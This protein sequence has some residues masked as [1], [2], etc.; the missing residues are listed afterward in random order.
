M[1][2]VAAGPEQVGELVRLINAAYA[3]G[4]AGLWVDGTP[5]TDEEEIGPAVQAGE[6]LAAILDGRLVGCVRVRALDADT[7]EVGLVSADPAAWGAG[8]GRAL[9]RAA[10][11][12]MR[13]RGAATMRLTLLVPRDGVHPAKERLRDWYTRL[14]YVVVGTMP[15]EDA[16]PQ[17]APSLTQ[18]CDLLLFRKA[19]P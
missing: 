18:P 16:V 5:R 12:R 11:D 4:E 14:G 6:M 1:R 8:V 2:V 17:A 13:A 9:M 10:E 3:A 7:G 19:L 15:F